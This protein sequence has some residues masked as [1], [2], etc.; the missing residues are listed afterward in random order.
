MGVIHL[1]TYPKMVRR[2][3]IPVRANYDRDETNRLM[4]DWLFFLKIW[5]QGDNLAESRD[6]RSF[7]S[8]PIGNTIHNTHIKKVLVGYI[9]I[10]ITKK[11]YFYLYIIRD[12]KQIWRFGRN[13]EFKPFLLFVSPPSPPFV[14]PSWMCL[15][16]KEPPPPPPPAY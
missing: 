13:A 4:V 16:V 3:S 8:V 1:C 2:R 5:L 11:L 6:S 15:P 12:T 14:R 9:E 10:I 7:G